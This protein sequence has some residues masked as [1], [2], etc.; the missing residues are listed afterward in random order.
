MDLKM[1]L[2]DE[3]NI[4]SLGQRFIEQDLGYQV[5]CADN[6]EDAR[7][8]M[9]ANDYRALMIEPLVKGALLNPHAPRIELIREARKKDIRVIISST[10]PKK[11]LLDFWGLVERFDYQGFFEKPYVFKEI[12][13]ELK[14]IVEQ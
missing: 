5:D 14:E 10:Q 13:S 6:V 2:V 3:K 1:L 12:V 4:T 7:Q 8:L 9:D 11:N